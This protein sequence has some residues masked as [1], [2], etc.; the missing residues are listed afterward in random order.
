[1]FVVTSSLI[2][3]NFW[4]HSR[5]MFRKCSHYKSWLNKQ[6]ATFDLSRWKLF[7]KAF[8]TLD[9]N[10]TPPCTNFILFVESYKLR[11]G[12]QHGEFSCLEVFPLEFF[13]S[14]VCG[15]TKT[16]LCVDC[17]LERCQLQFH[18]WTW[19]T[20]RP[21][22]CL[23]LSE[24]KI[25]RKSAT[26]NFLDPHEQDEFPQ[27]EKFV[28]GNYFAFRLQFALFNWKF[29]SATWTLIPD[30]RHSRVRLDVKFYL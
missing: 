15:E 12:W 24:T 18:S 19:S 6:A 22:N 5:C 7:V 21:W 16:A 30:K 25:F 10:S 14:K 29:I 13:S 4:F 2:F 8:E 11:F 20:N 23:K 17:V 28:C 3:A 27:D 1:M 9:G 26:R